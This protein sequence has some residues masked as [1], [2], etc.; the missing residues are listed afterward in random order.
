M[1]SI[2]ARITL[3]VVGATSL[4]VALAAL[5][6]GIT[7]HTM[8]MDALDERLNASARWFAVIPRWN[9]LP[10]DGNAATPA[11][12]TTTTVA[13]P[14]SRDGAPPDRAG[15]GREGRGGPPGFS[16]SSRWFLVHDVA[17]GSEVASGGAEL[18]ENFS[19][20]YLGVKP[21]DAPIDADLGDGRTL[22]VTAFESVSV[23]P[24]WRPRGGDGGRDGSAGNG[25]PTTTSGDSSASGADATV[26]TAPTATEPRRDDRRPAITWLAIEATEAHAEARRLVWLLASAWLA[27][28]AVA[29]VIARMTS[30]RVLA[31]VAQLSHTIAALSPQHLSAR[32]PMEAVPDELSAMIGRLNGL[33]QRVESAFERERAT[34]ANMAHEL[35]TPIAALRAE[36]EFAQFRGDTRPLDKRT[37][38]KSLVLALRMQSL[39]SGLLTMSR[40]ESGQETLVTSDVDVARVLREAWSAIE[41]RAKERG[42]VLR[43]KA[44]ATLLA[45]TSGEH[46]AM[47]AANLLDNALAHG[48]AGDL[49]VELEAR[50]SVLHLLIENRCDRKAPPAENLFEPF[51]RQDPSRTGER[52][53]GLGLALCDRV[54]RLLGGTIA[55]KQ[56]DGRF[57][58]IVELPLRREPA[59]AAAGA[60]AG[61]AA[62]SQQIALSA[63]VSPATQP[64]P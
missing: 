37:M 15:G 16:S 17:D 49:D 14:G 33:L 45:H 22:R 53:F 58:V 23:A 24:F 32:V 43:S 20:A 51:W 56:G 54:V 27:A 61:A 19:L 42:L 62:A 10:R 60:G 46:L 1:R 9:E 63:S 64:T 7:G 11:A 34:I 40:I 31:P 39:V 29:F 35:R 26:P 44:P 2:R 30:K 41:E 50:G 13:P 36:L 47:V 38:E 21:G 5:I 3:A 6:V 59:P 48:S 28:T 25:A 18:P 57:T 12:T 8:L 55:A 4:S 52:H